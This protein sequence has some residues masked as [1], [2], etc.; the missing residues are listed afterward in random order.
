MGRPIHSTPVP[1]TR[2]FIEQ[3]GPAHILDR[4]SSKRARPIESMGRSSKRFRTH[5][6][7][8]FGKSKRFT[9]WIHL[10]LAFWNQ[11]SKR[12]AGFDSDSKEYVLNG[13]PYR[14]WCT[15]A[16]PVY[17]TNIRTYR[18]GSGTPNMY[19]YISA[20]RYVLRPADAPHSLSTT[21]R[22][23]FTHYRLQTNSPVDVITT[24]QINTLW[25]TSANFANFNP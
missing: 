14:P 20:G 23:F 19:V 24:S 21:I 18:R 22:K 25:A 12:Y 2:Q 1:F 6:R 10:L 17:Y 9:F 8:I 11:Q 7:A 16:W 13:T 5:T 3:M 15:P 4:L